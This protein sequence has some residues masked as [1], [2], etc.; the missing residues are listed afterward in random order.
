MD[1]FNNVS[2]GEDIILDQIYIKQL[3][4]D[5][6]MMIFDFHNIIENVENLPSPR[7]RD[8][9]LRNHMRKVFEEMSSWTLLIMYLGMRTLFLDQIYIK[10]ICPDFI[11]MIFD[12]HNII[13]KCI[14]NIELSLKLNI[15]SSFL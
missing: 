15:I 14:L 7:L 6:I 1:T 4:P 2:R 5:F 9:A 12:F 10:Q 13:R 11:M 8:T 3:C